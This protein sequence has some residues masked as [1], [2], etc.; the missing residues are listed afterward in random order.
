M[1][2]VGFVSGIAVASVDR[3]TL[4]MSGLILVFVEAFSMAVGSFL[5][6]ESVRQ[7]RLHG[8]ATAG[9][10]VLGGAVMF[11]SYLCTGL[12]VLAPYWFLDNGGSLQLS[13]AISLV[14]LFLLGAWSARTA[15]L[16]PVRRGIRMTVVGGAA[17]A[18]GILVGRITS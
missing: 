11:L 15:G 1:S 9:P 16:S 6:D 7:V 4:L 17:I 3:T 13:V 18:L 12:I 14:A 8:R 5:S 10:S 2:T